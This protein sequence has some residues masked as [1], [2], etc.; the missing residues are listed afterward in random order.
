[1][2]TCEVC[3]ND[4]DKSFE[5]T[6]GGLDAHV[7]QLRVRDPRPRADVR[8][9]RLPRDR[10]RGGGRRP[11]LLLRALRGAGRSG[12]ALGPNLVGRPSARFRSLRRARPAG[13]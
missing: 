12:R 4:Y 2:A 11:D 8:A 13:K 10:A 7:R 3:G 9:L 5:V 6:I 1:M